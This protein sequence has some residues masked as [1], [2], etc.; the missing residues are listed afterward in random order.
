[1]RTQNACTQMSQIV[2]DHC[3]GLSG[4]RNFGL[5]QR[6]K[7]HQKQSIC[8]TDVPGVL[9][10]ASDSL[11][12]CCSAT[13]KA[14]PPGNKEGREYAPGA[15][16]SSWQPPARSLRFAGLAEMV[17]AGPFGLGG[18]LYSPGP[19][20]AW[21]WLTSAGLLPIVN[22]GPLSNVLLSTW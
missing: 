11:A 19:G 7:I 18:E 12:G 3:P 17:Y 1:M 16:T 4:L 20:P 2:A 15:G 5:Q 13:E 9:S 8:G 21:R 10:A 14:G 22:A 6:L